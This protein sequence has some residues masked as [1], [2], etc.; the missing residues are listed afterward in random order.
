MGLSLFDAL[1]PL[2]E[3]VD[4]VRWREFCQLWLIIGLLMVG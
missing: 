3:Y 2:P 4:E 1:G